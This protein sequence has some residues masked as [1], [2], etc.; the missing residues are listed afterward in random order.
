MRDIPVDAGL[1]EIEFDFTPVEMKAMYRPSLALE[2]YDVDD[3][4]EIT[5][6]GVLGSKLLVRLQRRT[7][8][9]AHIKAVWEERYLYDS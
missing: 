8:K 7:G 3:E 4:I 2:V 9:I 1:E 6:I 5:S